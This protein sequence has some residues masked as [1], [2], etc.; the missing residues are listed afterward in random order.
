MYQNKEHINKSIKNLLMSNNN[1]KTKLLF[2]Q[3][4]LFII[5]KIYLYLLLF[6][7]ISYY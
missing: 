4:I 7:F 5:Y 1:K 6:K 3:N 2:F